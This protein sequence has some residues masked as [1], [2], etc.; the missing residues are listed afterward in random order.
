[1]SISRSDTNSNLFNFPESMITC[2]ITKQIFHTP[3]TL[4]GSGQTIEE[5]QAKIILQKPN[6]ICPLTR[7]PITGYDVNWALKDI[8]SQYMLAH[9]SADQYQPSASTQHN[10]QHGEVSQPVTSANVSTPNHPRSIAT[11]SYSLVADIASSRYQ[12]PSSPEPY[13]DAGR[14]YWPFGYT[15]SS[16]G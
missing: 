8:V 16:G 12:A 9:P 11:S 3:V 1:M 6:P 10:D 15:Y 4:R 7:L 14:P 13:H 5:E 2:P